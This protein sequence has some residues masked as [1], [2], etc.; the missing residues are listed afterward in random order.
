MTTYHIDLKRDLESA[1]SHIRLAI[2]T[3]WIIEN[4]MSSGMLS[5]TE[6]DAHISTIKTAVTDGI[7]A[8]QGCGIDEYTGLQAPVDQIS[9]LRISGNASITPGESAALL[10]TADYENYKGMATGVDIPLAVT[11][12][13]SDNAI[14]SVNSS[15]G[16]ATAEAQGNVTIT[17]RATDGTLSSVPMIVT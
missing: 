5:N 17:A 15:T 11:W 16:A 12:V 10:A 13:S 8:L 2:D 4:D 7:S 9:T 1:L 3:A 6:V 14:V